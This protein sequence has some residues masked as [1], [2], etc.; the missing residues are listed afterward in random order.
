MGKS[1]GKKKKERKREGVGSSAAASRSSR[2]SEKGIVKKKPSPSVKAARSLEEL[3]EENRRLQELLRKNEEQLKFAREA[4]GALQPTEDAKKGK[5]RKMHKGREEGQ[6]P[7]GD[8]RF[9]MARLANATSSWRGTDKATLRDGSGSDGNVA[10]DGDGADHQGQ[11]CAPSLRC[12]P[13]AVG[14]DGCDGS[15]QVYFCLLSA[16]LHTLGCLVV[17]GGGV[18]C[19]IVG[20]LI[21]VPT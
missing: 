21:D 16:S 19:A 18:F 5:S 15:E 11:V 7:E 13:G 3:E 2:L 14:E 12:K 10:R 8:R 1:E 6:D 4:Q 20:K 17:R 9:S